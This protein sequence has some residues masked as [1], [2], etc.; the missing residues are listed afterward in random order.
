MDELEYL[1]KKLI[2]YRQG[3][4][5]EITCSDEGV[6]L[7][8]R[9]KDLEKEIGSIVGEL[10]R[11]VRERFRE[12]TCLLPPIQYLTLENIG[13]ELHVLSILYEI[14]SCMFDVHVYV[15]LNDC[16]E[17]FLITLYLFRELKQGGEADLFKIAR[18]GNVIVRFKDLHHR[19]NV[20]KKTLEKKYDESLHTEY[21]DLVS[22]LDELVKEISRL[23]ISDKELFDQIH[24][25]VFPLDMDRRELLDRIQ[26]NIEKYVDYRIKLL[27]RWIRA[28]NK[29]LRIEGVEYIVVS[30]LLSHSC[31]ESSLLDIIKTVYD[32]LRRRN[33]RDIVFIAGEDYLVLREVSRLDYRVFMVNHVSD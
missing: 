32:H 31:L 1:L 20:L 8:L 16:S 6:S 33:C 13:R 14:L 28:L 25:I 19:I 23:W 7:E 4:D 15:V 2:N 10:D 9:S 5:Y 22:E 26:Q 21:L 30:K 11:I 17:D 29:Y 3:I 12:H 18:Y 24:S 27:D